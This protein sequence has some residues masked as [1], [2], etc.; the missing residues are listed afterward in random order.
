MLRSACV[1]AV[2]AILLAKL[3]LV[4]RINVNWDEF[5]FLSLVHSLARGELDL[6]LQGAYTHLFVWATRLN[7]DE[8]GQIIWLRLT[9]WPLLA[10]SCFLLYRLAR[11]FASP[12]GAWFAVMAFVASWPVLKHGISFRADSMLLPLTLAIFLLAS[13]DNH[14]AR[15]RDIGIGVLLGLALVLTVKAALPLPALMAVVL[16]EAQRERRGPD[17]LWPS[18]LRR[19]AVIAC[20][21]GLTMALILA[22]H[23]NFVT[24]QA[25]RPELLLTSAMN[26]ALLD[27]PWVPR[28][29]YFRQMLDMDLTTW[30]LLATGLVVAIVRRRFVAAAFVLSL[31]PVLFYR[32]AFPYYYVVMLAP[33]CVVIGVVIDGMR[34]VTARTGPVTAG[35]AAVSI[36]YLL[37]A[38]QAWDHIMTLRFDEQAAQRSVISA[39]HR[40]FPTAVPYIDHSGMISSF[41]KVNFFMSTWGVES[42]LA[43]GEDFMPGLLAAYRPPLLLANHRV[44]IPGTLLFRQL[45]ETDQELIRDSYVEYWG[46]V[47]VAGTEL[48]IPSGGIVPARLPFAGTYRIES[49]AA[50]LIDGQRHDP[51]DRIEW[52]ADSKDL[53]IQAVAPNT[54]AI[55]VRM[56]WDA[57]RVPPSDPP[58]T[59]QLYSSL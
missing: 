44:L 22:V 32:N 45:R 16:L 57:A 18:L 56:I 55:R 49:N 34:T 39:V 29:N 48:V 37:L 15:W 4:W 50:I 10:L 36:F 20:A 33:A 7:A 31:L 42:Y 1:A 21:G 47:R 58:P 51:G 46:P 41:P 5:Y 52:R 54:A 40:I 28:W 35:I 3:F 24:S 9:M 6:L 2:A 25:E 26:S 59:Q 27:V 30:F 23:A 14:Q 43:R 19:L 11:R 38:H 8:I 53:S 17:R 13:S 12:A